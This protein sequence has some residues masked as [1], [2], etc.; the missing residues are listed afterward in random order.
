MLGEKEFLSLVENNNVDYVIS[1]DFHSY[2]RAKVRNTVF[3]ISGGGTDKFANKAKNEKEGSYHAMLIQVDPVT[4]NVNERIYIGKS[5]KR[6]FYVMKKTMLTQA[7]AFFEHEEKWEMP[8]MGSGGLVSCLL[9]IWFFSSVRV[10]NRKSV[11]HKP[12]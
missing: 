1:G 10:S 7:F 3:L 4:R 12:Q 9:G 6:P 11:R 2:F 5:Q 8:I